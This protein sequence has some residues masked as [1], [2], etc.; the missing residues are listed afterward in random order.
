MVFVHRGHTTSK[1]VSLSDRNS[2]YVLAFRYA[3]NLKYSCSRGAGAEEIQ[4]PCL[5]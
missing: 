2:A 1:S 3:W 4:G 5:L